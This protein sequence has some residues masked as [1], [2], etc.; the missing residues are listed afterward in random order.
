MNI[1]VSLAGYDCAALIMLSNSADR[2]QTLT[3]G[4]LRADFEVTSDFEE[5]GVI[6]RETTVDCQA[7]A[8]RSQ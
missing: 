7:G 4:N 5:Q 1:T 8:G 2:F 3:Q 6:R